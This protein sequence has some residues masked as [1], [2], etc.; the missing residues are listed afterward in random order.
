VSK[1]IAPL[2]VFGAVLVAMVA[3]NDGATSPPALSAERGPDYAAVGESH[4]ERAR[5]TGDPGFYSRAGRA[6]DRAL[7]SDARS[8]AALV[9]AGTL[10]GLRHDFSEQLRLGIDARRV[11]PQLARPLTVIAD[12]QIE[13]GRYADARRSIQRLVD[14]K[15]SLPAYARVSYYRELHGDL[16]GAV[17]AMRFAVSAGGSASSDAYVETLLGDLQLARGRLTAAL[18]AYRGALRD[19]PSFP[20]ALTGLARIDVARGELGSAAA[21]L[22]RSTDRLPL[23][24]SLVLLAEV[25]SAL[26]RRRQARADLAAARAQHR[27]LR[28]SRTLPDAEAVLFE[29]NH[30]SPQRAVSLGQ[31]VWRRAPSIR[32]ADALGWALTRAGRP[33]AGVAWARRAL[34]TGSIDPMFRLHAGVAALRAGLRPEAERYLTAAVRGSAAL[35]PASARLLREARS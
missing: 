27:L 9:G 5:E 22:R 14:L 2:A 6:F 7:K 26:G 8:V 34:R 13:L 17:E 12:A 25:E 4:L 11:A 16:G 30:G 10:A 15:P 35:S 23:T 33:G 24:S 3:L 32:S 18:R 28:G 1:L 21:R 31:R 19:L 20:P 29:A